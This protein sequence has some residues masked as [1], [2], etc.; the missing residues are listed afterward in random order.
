MNIEFTDS[1]QY[2]IEARSYSIAGIAS[3]NFWVLRDH[4]K[5]VI[6]QLHGLATD[7]KTNTFKPIGIFN[8]RLG[9]YEFKT[10]NQDPS[11]IFTNQNSV[12]VF[13]GSKEDTL[14]R[15]HKA[16]SQIDQLNHLDLNYTAFGILGLS[17]TN[18]NSAYHLFSK[19]MG[20]E[21]CRFPGVLEPGI[22]NDLSDY[23]IIS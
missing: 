2:I 9:F 20:I 5:H 13:K 18:S 23:F 4:K 19:L 15:W 8:D 10:V 21:C 22:G 11:F 14:M 7:R 12:T 3:H 1:K 17:V 16:A 6:A